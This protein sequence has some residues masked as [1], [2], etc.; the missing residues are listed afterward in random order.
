MT[1]QL[2]LFWWASLPV[3]YA[4]GCWVFNRPVL[5]DYVTFLLTMTALRIVR[6]E[7]EDVGKDVKAIKRARSN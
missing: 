5:I 2:E 7:I 1:R 6:W 4:V 3:F